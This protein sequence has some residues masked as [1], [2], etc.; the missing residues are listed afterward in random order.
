MKLLEPIYDKLAADT[1]VTAQLATYAFDT[2]GAETAAVFTG[3]IPDDAE[4]PC[5]LLSVVTSV[6]FDTRGQRG[7]DTTVDIRVY[8]DRNMTALAFRSLCDDVWK[9]V[10]RADL[11][12]QGAA[13]GY[14]VYT[15][16]A[17]YPRTTPE[18]DGYPAAWLSCRVQALL[19]E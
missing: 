12:S 4:Y 9:S 3:R 17:S 11:S 8:G 16:S 15:V 13:A 19:D 5:L 6:P 14:D 10:N 2:G 1:T 7:T 18:T